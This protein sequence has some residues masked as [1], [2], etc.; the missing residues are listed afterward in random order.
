MSKATRGAQ[1]VTRFD[2]EMFSLLQGSKIKPDREAAAMVLEKQSII[3]FRVPDPSRQ[4]YLTASLVT[5][6]RVNDIRVQ[7][8]PVQ[9]FTPPKG[10][11]RVENEGPMS[12]PE[13]AQR[14]ALM[15]A[16]FQTGPFAFASHSES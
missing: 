15:Q 8:L 16:Q 3:N 10:Y 2:N 13:G 14:I 5:K 1:E 11:T 6:A 4:G 7:Q 12:I 9:T